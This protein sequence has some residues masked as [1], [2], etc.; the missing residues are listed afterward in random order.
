MFC[1]PVSIGKDEHGGGACITAPGGQRRRSIAT[2]GRDQ[3]AGH[4][5]DGD[6]GPAVVLSEIVMETGGALQDPRG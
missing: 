4:S 6:S 3:R 1:K 5:L 2:P